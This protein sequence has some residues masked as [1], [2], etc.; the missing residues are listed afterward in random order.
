MQVGFNLVIT[1]YLYKLGYSAIRP[2]I[3]ILKDILTRLY[4]V[5]N[6]RVNMR[7]KGK[8]EV[9]VIRDNIA[10]IETHLAT[11]SQSLNKVHAIIPP[12]V[13]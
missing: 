6:L 9:C 4:R 1:L 13:L 11:A 5:A 10:V 3:Y 8:Q 2:L 7:I 12:L